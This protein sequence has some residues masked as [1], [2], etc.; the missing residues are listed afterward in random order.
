ML[1]AMATSARPMSM[2]PM[3]ARVVNT[4]VAERNSSSSMSNKSLNNNFSTEEQMRGM[5]ERL[6]TLLAETLDRSL[7]TPPELDR[8]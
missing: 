8:A 3:E 2:L 1:T 5:L 6:V 4:T 7:F